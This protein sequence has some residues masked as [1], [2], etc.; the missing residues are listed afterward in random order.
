MSKKEHTKVSYQ[1]DKC[2]VTL[3]CEC[4]DCSV[5][6]AEFS[7]GCQCEGWQSRTEDFIGWNGITK[8]QATTILQELRSK[9]V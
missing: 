4:K 7:N 8:E 2:L 1:E 6:L 5:P 9:A 3:F